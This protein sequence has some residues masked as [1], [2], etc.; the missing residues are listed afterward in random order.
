MLKVENLRKKYHSFL[1]DGISFTLPEGYILGFIG[2]NGAGK[3]T[4]I[5]CLTGVNPYDEGEVTVF[6]KDFRTHSLEILQDVGFSSGAMDCYPNEKVE[7]IGRTYG[8]FF[9]NYDNGKFLRLCKT[10][11]IDPSKKVR[12]LSQ[13]MKVKLGIALALSHDAK[14]IILDEPTS[15]L[16]PVA[17]EELLDLLQKIMEQ[18]NRSILFSTHVTSDLDKCADYILFINDGKQILF[19]TKDNIVD[20]HALVRGKKEALTD[21]L[22]DRLIGHK[23]TPIGFT[24]LIKREDLTEYDDVETSAPTL[25]D[26]M[27]YYVKEEIVL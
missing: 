1:L 24:G 15:G 20:G 13:G 21:S 25:E 18:G 17:R 12:E 8:I 23:V 16:D 5:K 4:T 3:S 6:G 22:K 2:Q 7:K 10:F 14:L 19:D 27:V 11:H 9:K 26:I